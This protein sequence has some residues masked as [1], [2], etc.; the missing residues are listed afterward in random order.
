[1]NAFV[2]INLWEFLVQWP[3]AY[4]D[5]PEWRKGQRFFNYLEEVHPDLANKLRGTTLDPF[6]RDDILHRAIEFVTMNWSQTHVFAEQENLMKQ[7]EEAIAKGN[8]IQAVRLFR[9]ANHCDLVTAK[10]AVLE[11]NK[12]KLQGG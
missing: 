7:C 10:N 12:K 11:M 8:L 1:M 2:K 4:P 5:C 3:Y 9:D 6:H